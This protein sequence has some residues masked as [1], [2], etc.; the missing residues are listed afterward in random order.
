MMKANKVMCILMYFDNI[1]W[2]KSDLD[3]EMMI[4]I[5]YSIYLQPICVGI[6]EKETSEPVVEVP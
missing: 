5:K 2:L 3:Y 4:C 6:Q 1:T